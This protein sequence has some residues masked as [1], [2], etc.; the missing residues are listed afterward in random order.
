MALT[1]RFTLFVW[2]SLVQPY[3]LTWSKYAPKNRLASMLQRAWRGPLVGDVSSSSPF[4]SGYIQ[5]DSRFPTRKSNQIERDTEKQRVE[6]PRENRLLRESDDDN[7]IV[8]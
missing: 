7:W 3:A 2:R 5:L 6:T 8:C 1:S 4:I